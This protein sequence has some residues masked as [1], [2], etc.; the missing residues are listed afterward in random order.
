MRKMTNFFTHPNALV[1]TD[2]IGADSKI[3][4]FVHILSGAQ[5]G[6]NVTICDNVFIENDVIIGDNVTIKCG[7]QLWDGM[8]VEDNVFIGPNATF[9]NDL[10]PRSKQ[11]AEFQKRFKLTF[12]HQ[13]ASIGANATILPGLTIGSHAM[14]GAGAVVTRNV[15][16]Y[17]IVAGNPARIKGYTSTIE[18]VVSKKEVDESCPEYS[19]SKIKNVRVIELPQVVDMRGSL[20][21]GEIE[22]HLPFL[23]KRFFT[24]YDVPTKETRGEH[25]H[26]TLQEILICVKGTC[27]VVV[28]DGSQRAEIEL[29]TPRH[30]LYIPPMVWRIHY[31][32]ST[33]AL[34]IV[35]ASE[36]YDASDYIRD[37]SEFI[38]LCKLQADDTTGRSANERSF[39]RT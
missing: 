30:A 25:A 34:V 29:N 28:D 8:R 23:P 6:S 22:S 12:I 15:P 3:W 17:A 18:E 13:G 14:V 31:K 24:I 1:E 35:L 10:Y 38:D 2:N 11:H 16:P 37:Y 4:A 9:T 26:K 21:F 33:N 7:V 27:S 36:K 5:I 20:S 39:S 19:V 32:Y